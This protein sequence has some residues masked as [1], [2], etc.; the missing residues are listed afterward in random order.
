MVTRIIGITIILSISIFTSSTSHM[1]LA[2]DDPHSAADAD[3]PKK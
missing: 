3:G 2:K 1:A